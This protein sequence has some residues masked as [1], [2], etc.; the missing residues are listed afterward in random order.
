LKQD[1]FFRVPT[2]AASNVGV[3]LQDVKIL[4]LLL[5]T[6]L[7][8]AKKRPVCNNVDENKLEQYFAAHILPGSVNNIVQHCMYSLNNIVN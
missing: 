5:K 6:E 4:D 1:V 2:L 3:V 8:T 7:Y